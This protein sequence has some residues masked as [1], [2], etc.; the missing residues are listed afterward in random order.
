MVQQ[1]KATLREEQQAPAVTIDELAYSPVEAANATTN[2]T[3]TSPA[4]MGAQFSFAVAPPGTDTTPVKAVG[5]TTRSSMIPKPRGKSTLAVDT[6]NRVN[7]TTG[8]S[9]PRPGSSGGSKKK[10]PALA[11]VK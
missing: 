6:E 8:T 11:Q 2:Q 9:I 4:M 10:K 1:R 7:A 3:S 5:M